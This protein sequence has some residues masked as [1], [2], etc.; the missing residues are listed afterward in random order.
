MGWSSANPIF[1]NVANLLIHYDTC[2]ELKYE[3]CKSL[4]E[5]LQGG[6][7]DTEGESLGE[8]QDDEAIVA[9][10]RACGVIVPCAEEAEVAGNWL[11]CEEE[12]DHNGVHRDYNG[13]EW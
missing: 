7:W 8:F 4:I 6:D 3:I 2:Y 10:F 5:T 9:A 13:H 1:E 11:Y 12:R